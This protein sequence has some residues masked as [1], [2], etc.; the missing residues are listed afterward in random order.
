MEALGSAGLLHT[1]EVR[2]SSPCAP[3]IVFKGLRRIPAL[4]ESTF[5]YKTSCFFC[6]FRRCSKSPTPSDHSLRQAS[7]PS[8][9]ETL[10]LGQQFQ[11]RNAKTMKPEPFLDGRCQ[12]LPA[13]GKATQPY[14]LQAGPGGWMSVWRVAG[15][16]ARDR[17]DLRAGSNWRCFLQRINCALYFPTTK[18]WVARRAKPGLTPRC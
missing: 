13:T 15:T 17:T 11:K 3:T 6:G 10:I 9:E 8:P 1:Q 14:S 16:G 18:I 5:G 4:R 2:G 12:L 7:E